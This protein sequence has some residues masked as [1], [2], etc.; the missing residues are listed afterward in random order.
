MNIEK[1]KQLCVPV[2]ERLS[3]LFDSYFIQ[4]GIHF[5][6]HLDGEEDNE[7]EHC[8]IE[9]EKSQIKNVFFRQGHGV[10]AF[11]TKEFIA[12]LYILYTEEIT[13]KKAG[14]KF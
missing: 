6:Y 5:G 12:N 4:D 1:L 13:T 2:S 8:F 9:I 11:P 3:H 14:M 10:R 7:L